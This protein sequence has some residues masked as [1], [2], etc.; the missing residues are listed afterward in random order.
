LNTIY[1]PWPSYGDEEISA[2]DHVLRSGKVNYWTGS[3]CCDFEERFASWADCRHAVSL[4]NGTIAL[5]LAL[6]CL[7]VT[8]GDEVI[9]TPLSFIASA[10]CVITAGATPVFAD[11][12]PETGNLS[13]AT[14][15]A[16]ITEKTRAVIAVHLGGIPCDMDPIMELAAL[17]GFYV[18]EDCAQAHGARYGG[19][20]VGSIGHVAAWSFCQ[21]KI[22]T[23]GGEGGMVT[24][25]D[26][27]LHDIIWS[28]KDHGKNVLL[29]KQR[30]LSMPFC[31]TYQ[32]IGSNGRM[33]GIQAAIGLVQLGLMDE[34]HKRRVRNS[35]QLRDAIG[36]IAG[37]ASIPWRN[38]IE[39]A[40][41]RET[42]HVRPEMLAK[43]WTRDAIVQELRAQGV[44]C[45]SGAAAELHRAPAFPPHPNGKSPDT[46]A[47]A[48]LAARSIA[49]CVHPTLEPAHMDAIASSVRAIMQKAAIQESRVPTLA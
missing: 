27:A 2:V 15:K 3:D 18:V 17:H 43:G 13:A 46:P 44:P 32:S 48:A 19:R 42:L 25:N 33:S 28:A 8:K 6:Q 49:F 10:S 5:E 7:G 26:T 1:P 20:S 9:V 35:H 38:G 24:T 37:L 22:I 45:S 11:V 23:T 36:G 39:T 29:R 4:A 34:W 31:E 41:Y 47:A 14:I 21:D 40:A 12:D 16:A 30:D